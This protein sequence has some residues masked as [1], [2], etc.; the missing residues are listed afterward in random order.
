[1]TIL[2]SKEKL[3]IRAFPSLVNS[4]LLKESSGISKISGDFFYSN[5]PSLI[6]LRVTRRGE[7]IMWVF[8]VEPR[9][10]L[11]KQAHDPRNQAGRNGTGYITP[12]AILAN[13]G[14]Q[15]GTP[16]VPNRFSSLA[17]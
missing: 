12:N 17:W 11:V 4:V 6:M 13:N 5:P 10:P 8:G 7:S 3:N 15:T 14:K 1:M 16:A 2:K 9:R